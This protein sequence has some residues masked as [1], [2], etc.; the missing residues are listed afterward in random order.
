MWGFTVNFGSVTSGPEKLA[1]AFDTQ[2][3]AEEWY[4]AFDQAIS[5]AAPARHQ[6]SASTISDISNDTDMT[7]LHASMRSIQSF[8]TSVD[9]FFVLEVWFISFSK[10]V[11]VSF[12]YEIRD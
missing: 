4:D 10:T 1:I 2:D 3:K 11:V 9:F 8:G 6:R 12:L 5:N 7:G